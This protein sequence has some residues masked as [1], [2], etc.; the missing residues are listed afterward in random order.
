VAVYA[1][2]V[3][4]QVDAHW[5]ASFDGLTISNASPGEL[6]GGRGRSASGSWSPLGRL[7]LAQVSGGLTAGLLRASPSQ[8]VRGEPMSDKLS[9]LFVCVHNA[10]RSQMTAG[11]LNLLAGGSRSAPP[12]LNPPTRS[13]RRTTQDL[14]QCGG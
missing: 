1:I 9:V 8:R 11:Y 7:V 5:S 4:G 6:A 10:G 3:I 2:R 14:V 12:A 13:T